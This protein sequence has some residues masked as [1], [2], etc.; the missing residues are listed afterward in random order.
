MAKTI[1]TLLWL[2]ADWH[3]G[4]TTAFATPGWRQGDGLTIS[5]SHTQQLIRR[6]HYEALG[7]IKAMLKGRRLIIVH[8]GD[9]VE[10]NHHSTTQIVTP[11]NNEHCAMHIALMEEALDY[12]GFNSKR[13]DLLY[14][15]AGTESHVG[16]EENWI[17]RDLGAVPSIPPT[18]EG[19]Y[20]DGRVTHYHLKLS[21]NGVLFDLSHHGGSVGQRAWT[22]ENGIRN[23]AK[24]I[25]L[26]CLENKIQIPRYWVR[27]HNHQYVRSGDYIGRQGSI[28]A[29]ITPAKQAKTHYGTRVAADNL[30]TIGDIWFT[31][32]KTGAAQ[33]H[34]CVM[35]HV[36][37]QVVEV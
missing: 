3:S 22:R 30:S 21:I 19:L 18:P 32:D 24:S 17:A 8:L 36:D 14:Y 15:V 2:P 1:D 10:G 11:D 31:I 25:Y 9:A 33:L 23:K 29:I 37:S 12:L 6:Q 27:A 28:E 16:T 13:G 7:R 5:Q 34:E 20:K 4:G 35:W 26:D